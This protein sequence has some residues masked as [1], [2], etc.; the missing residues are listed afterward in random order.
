MGTSVP[1]RRQ[2]ALTFGENASSH[3]DVDGMRVVFPRPC[4][5]VGGRRVSQETYGAL[6]RRGERQARLSSSSVAAKMR[7]LFGGART[8][9]RYFRA[10]TGWD[11]TTA[12]HRV[13][14]GL[15]LYIR[16]IY[17]LPRGD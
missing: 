12:V 13:F 7:S 1:K 10:T 8:C 15:V 16:V 17:P 5:R 14:Q 11:G 4:G 6:G 2:G 9:S 3:A